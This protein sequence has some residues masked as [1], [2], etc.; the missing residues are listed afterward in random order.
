MKRE[1]VV[2]LLAALIQVRHEIHNGPDYFWEEAVADAEG[3]LKSL[4][5]KQ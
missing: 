4:E 2:A 5:E 1:W 3:R